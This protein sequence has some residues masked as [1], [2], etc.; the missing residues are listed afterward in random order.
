MTHRLIATGLLLFTAL[1]TSS[2]SAPSMP[3]LLVFGDSVSAGYGIRIEEGWVA[4]LQSRLQNQGYGYRVVNAS[5]SGETTAG[6]L[7]RLPR[8]LQLHRPKIVVIELGGNDG[9]RGLPLAEVRKNLEAMMRAARASGAKVLLIGMRLPPNYGGPY[10]DSFQAT[11]G[12][13]SKH[14]SV[15]LVPFLLEGVAL[16]GR[17]MQPDGIHPTAAAQPRLLDNVWPVLKPLLRP[18]QPTQASPT[19]SDSR[20]AVAQI[21]ML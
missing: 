10:V 9:L 5:V 6:G 4:L 3:A 21:P 7:A 13:L 20:V 15:P 1:A 19:S 17:L 12:D 16:D 18:P 11:Y 2:G 14:Y 8:A